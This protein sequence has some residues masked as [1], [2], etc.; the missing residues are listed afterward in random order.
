MHTN[1][2][3]SDGNGIQMYMT[4]DRVSLCGMFTC[5]LLFTCCSGSALSFRIQRLKRKTKRSKIMGYLLGSIAEE[6]KILIKHIKAWSAH[7]TF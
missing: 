3:L 1:K 4:K 6:I 2:R 5:C 7:A